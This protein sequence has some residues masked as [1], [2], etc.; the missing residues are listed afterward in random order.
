M[1]SK[2][3]LLVL[4]LQTSMH[5]V[6]VC[7]VVDVVVEEGY[8]RREG[9]HKGHV[10]DIAGGGIGEVRGKKDGFDGAVVV[11]VVVVVAEEVHRM[12]CEGMVGLVGGGVRRRRGSYGKGGRQIVRA[13]AGHRS[14]P[15]GKCVTRD[16]RYNGGVCECAWESVFVLI[17]WSS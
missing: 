10:V 2:V 12:M 4:P 6:V 1:A 13:S 9:L 7:F 16:F 17:F 11:V 14:R 15:L 3:D 8:R 5:V